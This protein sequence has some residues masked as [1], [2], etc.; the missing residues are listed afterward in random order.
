MKK[1]ILVL[2]LNLILTYA[3]AQNIA[4]PGTFHNTLVD[5]ILNGKYKG[6]KTLGGYV[7]A[8]SSDKFGSNINLSQDLIEKVQKGTKPDNMKV[9]LINYKGAGLLNDNLFI[10]LNSIIDYM[11]NFPDENILPKSFNQK[12]DDFTKN[13]NI[14]SRNT[15]AIS[16]AISVLEKS[17]EHQY[18]LDGQADVNNRTRCRG[19]LRKLC[20]VLVDFGV[21]ALFTPIVG[22]AGAVILGA[23]YSAAA[24]CCGI[25][26]AVTQGCIDSQLCCITFLMGCISQ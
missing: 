21:T 25:C 22:P 17:Y 6:N 9:S 12:V 14:E 18:Q 3:N 7:N 19:F 26:C 11:L 2:F 20:I 1:Y 10:L 8:I 24:S 4:D 16:T 15:T 23:L 5:E 13:L